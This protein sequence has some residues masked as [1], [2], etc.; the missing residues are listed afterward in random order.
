[1]GVLG[2]GGMGT[3]YLA[4]HPRLP[5]RL[6]LKLLHPAL[7]DKPVTRARFESEAEHAAKLH[8]PNIIEVYDRGDSGAQLWISMQYIDGFDAA[9][10]V[11]RSG[12]LRPDHAVHIAA[13]VGRALD[14]AHS[15]GVLHRDVKPA[16]IMLERTGTDRPG[17]VLLGDF[18]ISKALAQTT[19][20][21][22][23][24]ELVA[25]LH[26]AAPEQFED[27]EL[28]PRCDVYALGCTLFE[29]LTGRVPYPG[30]TVSQ[31]WHGHALKPIPQASRVRSNLPVALDDVFARALAKD[32]RDRYR[33]CGELAAAAI[34]ALQP[35]RIPVQRAL[36]VT[37]T[38][39]LPHPGSI[40]P[41]SGRPGR[42]RTAQAAKL[43]GLGMVMVLVTVSGWLV[44]DRWL[45]AA[46]RDAVHGVRECMQAH[47]W[48]LR[49]T[50][51][52]EH[53]GADQDGHKV[54]YTLG[55][56]MIAHFGQD[57]SGQFEYDSFQIVTSYTPSDWAPITDSKH[58]IVRF[59][60]K[61]SVKDAGA[62]PYVSYSNVN[63]ELVK[64][65]EGEGI[66]TTTATVSPD[67]FG[68]NVTCTD[69]ELV[70]D[71]PER[72][73][74]GDGEARIDTFEPAS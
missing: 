59:E 34:H 2:V 62:Q 45:R 68:R 6:A 24:G 12:A 26:Y 71:A 42:R 51:S 1:M 64:K 73:S 33:S 61:L 3:V 69:T 47:N 11:A 31:V 18:G 56:V 43:F 58:G 37:P 38:A 5:K 53:S 16:N 41:D 29:F 14:F 50:K 35:P 65:S 39:P 13:E 21:T 30:Q 9:T 67:L 72:A 46:P 40:P 28:D 4:E 8:H 15:G 54:T 25:S 20:V 74:I 63:G 32:R 49:E 44:Y 55:G 48:R 7:T 52:P 23:R 60:Y 66:S 10:V 70:L 36:P 19:E 17:R 57:G 22:A 27:D